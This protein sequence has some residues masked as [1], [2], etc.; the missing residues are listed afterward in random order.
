MLLLCMSEIIENDVGFSAVLLNTLAGQQR[1]VVICEHAENLS[2]LASTCKYV[3]IWDTRLL[4]LA[5]SCRTSLRHQYQWALPAPAPRQSKPFM[6]RK[7]GG[8]RGC[9][10]LPPCPKGLWG[11]KKSAGSSSALLSP[12]CACTCAR[13]AVMSPC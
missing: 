3:N 4:V 11:R 7:S 5:Y 12:P 6:R 1:F 10:G 13:S 2:E 8:K 9:P